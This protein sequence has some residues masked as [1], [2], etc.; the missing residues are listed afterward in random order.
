M[1]IVLAA[2]TIFIFSCAFGQGQAARF[3]GG[4]KAQNNFITKNLDYPHRASSFY[5]DTTF[6]VFLNIDTFGKATIDFI[7]GSNDDMGFMASIERMVLKMPAWYPATNRG[8]KQHSQALI[9]VHFRH[10]KEISKVNQPADSPDFLISNRI[11]H[12]YDK[13]PKFRGGNVLLKR[14][15]IDYFRNTLHITKADATVRIMMI[16]HTDGHVSGVR[17]LEKTGNISSEHWVDAINQ[18]GSWIPGGTIDQDMNFQ[19]LFRLNLRYE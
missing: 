19:Y 12:G 8:E 11:G 13:V 2:I 1:R 6:K 7:L 3:P 15:L 18:A 5:G 17:V 14:R 4:L 9:Q 10:S 16:V